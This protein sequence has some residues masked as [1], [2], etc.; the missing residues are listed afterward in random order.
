MKESGKLRKKLMLHKETIRVL[1]DRELTRV[2]GGGGEL[3]QTCGS[4]R[5]TCPVTGPTCF[6]CATR[7]PCTP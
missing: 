4:P 6:H 2:E 1:S 7:Y 5:S 3:R